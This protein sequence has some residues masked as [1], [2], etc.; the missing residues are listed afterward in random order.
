[1]SKPKPATERLR[2]PHPRAADHVDRPKSLDQTLADI[3][4]KTAVAVGDLAYEC[5][6]IRA[7]C[8]AQG[9]TVR[10][11]G[12]YDPSA[13]PLVALTVEAV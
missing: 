3:G 13:S 4:A 6:R 10:V 1:M 11:T 2:S 12:H 7:K 8:A 9:I 5:E